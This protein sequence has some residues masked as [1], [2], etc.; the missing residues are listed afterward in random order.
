MNKVVIVTGASGFLGKEFVEKIVKTGDIC[1]NA[2]INIEDKSLKKINSNYYQ[3]N[4]DITSKKSI[5]SVIEQVQ[6]ECSRID[7][8]VNNAYPRN[9]NY[10]RKLPDVEYKDFC[11]N[12][13][14]HLGGYFLCMQLVSE[15]FNQNGGGNIINIASIYGV[16]APKFKIYEDTSMTMPVEYSVIKSGI[17]IMSKYFANYYKGHNIRV[18]CISPGGLLNNQPQSFLAN[19]KQECLN[20]GMLSPEDIS[21]TLLFLISDESKYVNGQN[22]VVDDGFT[23]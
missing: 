19:Y 23:L 15:Y 10:G 11:E 17:I 21:G 4:I 14:V 9:K 5:E 8:W 18:N 2:D 3:I 22:L 1:I 13:N 16:I 6:Q 20:K 12:I 7:C